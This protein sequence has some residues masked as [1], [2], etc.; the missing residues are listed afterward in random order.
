M[1]ARVGGVTDVR[2]AGLLAGIEVA[3]TDALPIVNAALD[4]GLIINRTSGNVVRLLPP[5]IATESD[6]DE[7]L[8]ILEASFEAAQ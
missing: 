8:A 3:M 5:Y 4:R 6:V 1:A 2:G 7:A